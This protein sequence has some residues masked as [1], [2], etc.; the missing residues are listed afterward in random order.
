MLMFALTHFLC[1]P[2]NICSL[3]I[4]HKKHDCG[5]KVHLFY[6]C[7]LQTVA[8]QLCSALYTLKKEE[9]KSGLTATQL[10]I[11]P[12]VHCDQKS[13]THLQIKFHFLLVGCFPPQN[14]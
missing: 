10:L 14:L 9:K 11:S 2:S 4:L 7:V 6:A 13:S 1:I 12:K 8:A 3:H 5:V